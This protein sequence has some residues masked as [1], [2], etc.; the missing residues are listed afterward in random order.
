MIDLVAA[1]ALNLEYTPIPAEKVIEGAPVTGLAELG[2]FGGH[3]YGVWEITP[4]VSSDVEAEE[5]FIV[6]TGRATVQ[7]LADGST[8]ELGPGSIGR[9]TEGM[10]TVWTVTETLRKVYLI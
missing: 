10:K 8:I 4:G 2:T 5:I 9:L 3:E 6:L 7:D 1:L